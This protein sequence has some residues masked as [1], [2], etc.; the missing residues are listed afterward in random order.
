MVQWSLQSSRL[1]AVI[2]H[3][4]TSKSVIERVELIPKH[5]T[6]GEMGTSPLWLTWALTRHEVNIKYFFSSPRFHV[7]FQQL[8]KVDMHQRF[9]LQNICTCLIWTYDV[10]TRY[11]YMHRYSTF[12]YLF[13]YY[14]IAVTEMHAH[15]NL[16]WTRAWTLSTH[17]ISYPD[18]LVNPIALPTK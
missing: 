13:H 6:V 16:P 14:C 15:K 1:Q 7:L 3:A 17:L 9:T 5:K 12:R 10:F 2:K 4:V 8:I 11:P 18:H